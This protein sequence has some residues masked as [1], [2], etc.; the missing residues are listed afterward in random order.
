[1]MVAFDVGITSCHGV[2]PKVVGIRYKVACGILF[3]INGNVL[4]G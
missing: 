4:F 2:S 3:R 1:M